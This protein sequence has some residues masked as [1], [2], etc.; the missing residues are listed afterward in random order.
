[1]KRQD[2][3]IALLAVLIAAAGCRKDSA[4]TYTPSAG[5]T[6]INAVSGSGSMVLNGSPNQNYTAVYS[7]S[8]QAFP[9]LAGAQTIDVTDPAATPAITYFNRT[10]DV[11]DKGNYSLFLAGLSPGQADTIFVT[12]TFTNPTDSSC[13]VRFINLSPDSGP[14]SVNIAGGDPGSETASLAYKSFTGFKS[15]SAIIANV[16]SGISFEVHDATTGDLLTTFKL[17]PSTFH[18]ITLAIAGPNAGLSVI[19]VNNF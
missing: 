12:E 1:M 16:I 11:A 10:V 5:I 17:T 7:F 2:I 4:S 9:L 18:N 6:I 8:S 13:G 19:Q 14:L 15:H 3:F